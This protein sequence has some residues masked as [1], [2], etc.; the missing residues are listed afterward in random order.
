[1]AAR[2]VYTMF[3]LMSCFAAA[4][5]QGLVKP[6]ALDRGGTVAL[7]APASPSSQ[8]KIDF[9]EKGLA[10]KDIGTK[11]FGNPM[12]VWGG[13]LAGKDDARAKAIMDAWRDPKV[14]AIFCIQGGYGTPRILKLLDYQ[15]MREHPKII[16][17][18]SDI[19]ALHLA[20]NQQAGLVTFHSPTTQW[21]YGGDVG[22]RPFA[23][24]SFWQTI[25]ADAF[26]HRQVRSAES[27]ISYTADQFT[28]PVTTINPGVAR[29]RLTGGNLSLVAALMGTPYEVETDG[30]L[31]FL[32]D[33]GEEPYRIDRMLST[34]DNAGKLDEVNGVILGIWAG[35]S[36]DD[37]EDFTAERV[38]RQ[39]FEGRP[40]P[41]VL[42]F[43]LGHVR[44]N[45]TLPAGL[46]AE[47][48]GADG[49]LRFLEEPVELP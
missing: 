30:A 16:A 48:N 39:Y 43:P 8:E 12:E 42:N 46:M 49:S 47:M 31:L 27:Y 36:P 18:F 1:M 29:G 38:F 35:C 21:V 15:Y 5:A 23:T 11:V 40:Y 44:E 32:E 24:E 19:T 28:S 13:Y 22:S 3:V 17:G 2:L 9:I 6:R 4:S 45:A 7:I 37:P 14:D 10:E 25:S 33:V 34:L 20:I 26:R 41:V